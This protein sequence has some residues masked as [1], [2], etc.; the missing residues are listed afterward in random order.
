MSESEKANSFNIDD[1]SLSVTLTV[2]QLKALV[3][4]EVEKAIQ[5]GHHGGDRL[6]GAKEASTLL[7][8]SEDWLYRN[9][10][11]LSFTRKLGRKVVRFSY[12]GIQKYLATR[13]VS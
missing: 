8:M 5:N 2:G 11:K 1:S 4:E 10:H 13:K 3:R 12:Q 7:A 9:A 6:L